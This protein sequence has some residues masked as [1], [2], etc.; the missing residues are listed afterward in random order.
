MMATIEKLKEY[1]KTGAKPTQE[2]FHALIDSYVHKEEDMDY[3]FGKLQGST[4]MGNAMPGDVPPVTTQKIFYTAT[5]AGKYTNFAGFVLEEGE[6]A[7]LVYDKAWIK[8]TLSML[9]QELG[10]SKEVAVSQ[11]VVKDELK[12]VNDVIK[13]QV[14]QEF[15]DSTK[16]VVSQ[17][18]VTERF[19]GIDSAIGEAENLANTKMPKQDNAEDGNIAVFEGKTAVDG[20]IQ[21]KN[22]A[23]Q[24]GYYEG[25]VVGA[26][27]SL[28]GDN[29]VRAEYVFRP[30]GGTDIQSGTA[31]INR[32]L[33]KTLVW[34][35]LITLNPLYTSNETNGLKIIVQDG[36][37][38]L[39]GTATAKV[40]VQAYKGNI[41]KNHKYAVIFEK[42][43][44]AYIFMDYQGALYENKIIYRPNDVGQIFLLKFVVDEGTTLNNYT[45]KINLFDLTQMF[46]EGNEPTTIEEFEA[47]F[48]N[49]YYE[50]NEGTLINNDAVGIK[51]VGFNAWD[52]EWVD[53]ELN[54]DGSI[55][56]NSTKHVT[57][58]FIRVIPNKKY[59][60]TL[61]DY[62]RYFWTEFNSDFK[63]ILSENSYLSHVAGNVDGIT[64]KGDYIKIVGPKD[65][66]TMNINLSHSGIRDGEYEPYEEH[67]LLFNN[68]NKLSAI[69]GKL[70][71]EGDSV[72]VFPDGL[73]SAG[74]ARDEI[75]GNVAIKRIGAVDMGTLNI[76][77]YY[78][79][80]ESMPNGLMGLR[81][82]NANIYN[83]IT[84]KYLCL[85]RYS[86]KDNVI[87]PNAGNE[88]MLYIVNSSFRLSADFKESLQGQIL[89]YELAEPE[90]YILDE[91]IPMNYVVDDWG[92]E[93]RLVADENE[94]L[95]PLCYDV[96]YAINAVDT[97]RNMPKNYISEETMRAFLLAVGSA[98]GG[99]WSM[100]WNE[101][102]QKYVF[103]FAPNAVATDVE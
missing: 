8:V 31:S 23:Q 32:V 40:N 68:G 60:I 11:K 33:G 3:L 95:A 97:I 9:A 28:A 61:D 38:V 78:Q 51:S 42:L 66:Q 86:E 1:F 30:S 67:K 74:N 59:K 27:R 49:D 53:G 90:T 64:F 79:P 14:V 96:T 58:N 98:M 84:A 25:M 50:Y 101:D 46:G 7:I 39:N 70:N 62:N 85:T 55:A 15:G 26:S 47:M 69:K 71:G 21:A 76:S 16:T 22:I 41:Y 13:N 12:K 2:Q 82:K 83:M 94:V 34:N 93:Q 88:E 29:E 72:V 63:N 17:K 20:K 99:K 91:A 56:N 57:K 19:E 48:P 45:P 4:Y 81:L 54:F 44:G 80:S 77:E 65:N 100:T 18:V 36:K 6:K 89:Y 43:E 92:T 5:T 35:Q 102:M 10:D 37:V 75:V 52:E 24:N 87:Y 103:T 73:R